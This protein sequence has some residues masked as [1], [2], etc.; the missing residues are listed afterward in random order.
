MANAVARG[1]L[2]SVGLAVALCAPAAQAAGDA[3]VVPGSRAAT[4]EHCVAPTP[5]MRLKHMKLILHQR[6]TMVHTG[7][8]STK[9]SIEDCV[10][11]HVS[12]TA[13]HKAVPINGDGQFCDSCHEYAAVRIDCFECH[14]SV[15]VP[16][17]KNAIG[18]DHQSGLER[19]ALTGSVALSASVLHPEV[20]GEGNRP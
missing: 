9:D 14:A 19:N 16:A 17:A 4:L 8:R 15:P 5:F 11:C 2:L 18:G 20:A 3:Y 1:S 7:V 10:A 12:Y 13:E 6:D